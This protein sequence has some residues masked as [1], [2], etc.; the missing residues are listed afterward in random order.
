MPTL[1]LTLLGD[2]ACALDGRPLR[3]ARRSALAL[4]VYL[5]CAGR[6]QRRVLLASLIAGDSDDA[7]ASMALRNGLRDLRALLG[8]QLQVDA[9]TVALAPS[10]ELTSDVAAFETAARTGLAQKSVALLREAFAHYGGE[11][12]PGLAVKGAPA[13][14]DWLIQER[15]RLRELALR[16]L[17]ELGAAEER[18]GDRTSAIATRRRLLA[19]EPWREE[20]HR[21]LMRL[22]AADGQRAAAL[23]QFEQ[24]R[25]AL[26]REL[27]IEPEPETLALLE[28]LQAGPVAPPHNLPARP[29]TFVD[30]PAERALLAEQLKH[31]GCRLVSVVGIGGAGKTRLALELG[32]EFTRPALP[33]Q[34][35]FP[36][37]VFLLTCG[38]AEGGGA[39]S[40]RRLSLA[41]LRS[42][43]LTVAAGDNPDDV[44]LRWLVP[45]RLL[46]LIDNAESEPAVAPFAR[47]VLAAAPEV[48][49][50]VTSRVRL[51][52]E[53]EWVFDMGGLVLPE[54]VED[55]PSSEAGQLFLER[56]RAVR[57]RRQPALGDYPHIL[58]ICRLVG[59]LP[60][61]I[62]LAAGRLRALSCAE[63]AEQ[64][65]GD[66]G[67]LV[68]EATDLPERQRNLSAVMRWSYSQL[69]PDEARCLRL[70]AV[71]PAMFD[72]AAAG[73]VSGCTG[74]QLEALV[75]SGLLSC[76]S[77]GT[78][79]LHP[80]VRQVAAEELRHTPDE[81]ATARLRHAEYF[82][83]RAAGLGERLQHDTTAIA[84][85]TGV[86]SDLQQAWQWAVAQG[87]LPHLRRL[88][89]AL[90]VAW[91]AL[92]L[93]REGIGACEGA[94]A[95]LG[96]G[97]AP[98]TLAP[99]YAA[100]LA[101]LLLATAWFHS[102]LAESERAAVLLAQARR[103]AGRSGRERL[104]ERL[105]RQQGMQLYLQ[106]RYSA[107]RPLLER[108]LA[109]ARHRGDRQGELEAI[110]VLARL[111]Y[112]VGDAA[113]MRTMVEAAEQRFQ[114]RAESV[115][116][117]YVHFSAAHLAADLHGDVAPGHALLARGGQA[118]AE[119]E[120]HQRQYWRWSLEWTLAY[121]EGR[122]A[123]AEELTSLV[124]TR[125]ASLRNGFIPVL[126]TIRLADTVLAQGDGAEADRLYLDALQRAMGLGTPLL[127]CLALLG[128]GR[129]A[130]LA[131]EHP[132]ARELGDE[133]QRL[134]RAEALQQL[135]PRAYVVLG[136][137]QAGL[138]DNEA[139]AKSYE[140]AFARDMANG[141]SARVAADAVALATTRQAQGDGAGALSLVVPQCSLLL[142]GP[143]TGMD[144]PIR[145]LLNAAELLQA[146]G[147]PRAEQLNVRARAELVRR[148]ELVRPER[149]DA[150]LNQIPAH[151]ALTNNGQLA[152][153]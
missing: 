132:R 29:T 137:A 34:L 101:E 103:F 96:R 133:A 94:A 150:F 4:A 65:A 135:T 108:A 151:R 105:D 149:R 41:L 129:V 80:L 43:N 93:F 54:G 20:A 17:S 117:D 38:E 6:T 127:K 67:L 66:L 25:A 73:A 116:M 91:D 140:E 71:F 82:A 77:D 118:P 61:G 99:D 13:F 144:E 126:A 11:F 33:D 95:T 89:P 112:R 21:A 130:L 59:G 45:R 86:W 147:D 84:E 26:Q 56:A 122:Y 1:S 98:D 55:L 63:I 139:A 28:Q 121:A 72:R 16:V 15:E 35:A 10:L 5:A 143:L 131:S 145:T 76:D 83:V 100:E 92:G 49:L 42:L 30:R 142:G 9:T 18:A 79:S 88:R 32:A 64:I 102:R 120:H 81:L 97:T 51:R 68:G 46:L 114:D 23:H 22:L 48:R 141:H 110:G 39:P 52:L 74:F 40:T 138:G 123:R 3:F 128:R 148:T 134:A 60:L 136:Q 57:V 78:F 124:L 75:D 62:V 44:L 50:L 106:T 107:A 27:G 90:A 7:S 87:S 36:D 85:L 146:A 14:D 69:T 47:A 152:L 37:G 58:R 109:V 53:A 19:E 24:C 31:P 115:E 119:Q 12:T 113:L 125:A 104:L 70:L 153:P 2:V 8:E 111:A